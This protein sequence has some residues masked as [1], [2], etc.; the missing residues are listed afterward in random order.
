MSKVTIYS[1][2]SSAQ[3]KHCAVDFDLR[4]EPVPV[5]LVQYDK[6]LPILEVSLYKGGA[7]YRLP[8]D[9][10]ANVR[11]GKF[12]NRVIYNPVLGCGE[13]RDKVYIAVTQ[14]MTTQ[15]GDFYPIVEVLVDGGVAGTSSMRLVVHRNPAQE[16][17][18]EDSSE[19][20]SL[21]ELVKQAAASAESARNDAEIAKQ[22]GQTVEA[23]AGNIQ[24][25]VDNLDAI[26]AAPGQAKAAAAS[27][28]AAQQAA[29]EALGFRTFFSAVTP[30]ANGDLDPSRTMATPTAASV[31]VKSKG[32]RIQSVQVNGF[33]TQ[34]GA[35]DPSPTNVRK[36]STVGMKLVKFTANGTSENGYTYINKGSTGNNY[37]IG[38]QNSSINAYTNKPYSYSTVLPYNANYNLDEPHFYNGTGELVVILP[39]T[40]YSNALSYLAENPITFWYPPV[41]ESQ[42]TGLYIP[43]QAQGHEYRCEM[44][45][46]TAPLCDGDKVESCVP[47]GCDVRL[48]FDGSSDENWQLSDLGATKR[49]LIAV[50]N[51]PATDSENGKGLSNLLS[52]AEPGGTGLPANSYCFTV[53]SNGNLYVKTDGEQTL[54]QF[55]ESLVKKNLV[56]YLRSTAYTEA[57]DIPVQL[58]THNSAKVV[59]DGTLSWRT[60]AG[61]SAPGSTYVIFDINLAGYPMG[62]NST[63]MSSIGVRVGNAWTNLLPDGSNFFLQNNGANTSYASRYDNGLDAWTQMLN[64]LRE[65]GTP[66]EIVYPSVT[67][68]I[69]AHD[70]VTLVAVP[71]TQAD[72]DAANQLASRPSMLPN[73]DSPDVPMLLDAANNAESAAVQTMAIAENAVPVAGTYVVSSQDGTTVALY[74]KAMQD[75]GDAAT[76]GGMTLDE[77]KQLISDAV[78]AAVQMAQA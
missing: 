73:I 77:I 37:R 27:A 21:D 68:V 15:E 16:D 48:V 78:T 35:G 51:V 1:P 17:A 40:S 66:F 36:I 58:E 8:E 39:A 42:A 3:I 28:A 23:N 10:E 63:G 75:G 41:D 19:A 13:N 43:I 38:V 59:D 71:Y 4:R 47:S 29:Q 6:T 32:D 45:E 24:A 56:F 57:N 67:P 11:M 54:E 31:T 60:S 33:T 50:K 53:G 30:D 9:A 69:Y 44:L 76:L 64:A 34:A 14:Q 7:P 65:A 46:L 70:P 49:F 20:K 2:P 5:H 12:N 55:K 26:K 61:D 72:V 25:V 22:A 18:I 52:I 62:I 74:L